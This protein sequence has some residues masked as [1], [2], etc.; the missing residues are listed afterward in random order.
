LKKEMMEM[1]TQR[2]KVLKKKIILKFLRLLGL[3]RLIICFYKKRQSVSKATTK[4]EKWKRES[5]DSQVFLWYLDVVNFTTARI[6]DFLFLCNFVFLWHSGVT[7]S[8]KKTLF[9]QGTIKTRCSL[10]HHKWL[11][12]LT[13][14]YIKIKLWQ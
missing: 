6:L 1:K 3:R 12:F 9:I 13:F 2:R 4:S 7:N 11:N 8:A 14:Y 10:L 5:S